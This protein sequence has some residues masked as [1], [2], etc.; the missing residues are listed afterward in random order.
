ME[1]IK[2][3]LTKQEFE[4]GLSHFYGTEAYHSIS[5]VLTALGDYVCTDGIK[6][7]MESLEKGREM[8][9]Y[10]VHEIAS[11]KLLKKSYFLSITLTPEAEGEVLCK[12]TDGDT[13]IL[14]NKMVPNLN[15]DF[16]TKEL[17]MYM[18]EGELNVLMLS[19]E[20]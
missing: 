12:I 17:R 11:R 6:F 4:D 13:E 18:V 20:Y 3:I 14:S 9:V 1:E 19:S 5:L 16:P 10:I 15:I 8:I 7:V 2:K